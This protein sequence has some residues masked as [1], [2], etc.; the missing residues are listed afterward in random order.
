L[1]NPTI[2]ELAKL[3]GVS[4]ATVSRCVNSPEKVGKKTLARVR[5]IIEETNFSPNALAQN[6]RRGKTN[7]IL[8]IIHDVGNPLFSAILEGV[9][10]ALAG[11]YS[12][13]L[14]EAGPHGPTGETVLG[15]LVARQVEGVILLCAPLPFSRKIVEMSRAR[16]L[17]IVIGL[18]PLSDD[19]SGLPNVHIDNFRAAHEATSYLISLGHK[20]IVFVSGP[21][22]SLVTRDREAGFLSAMRDGG[23]EVDKA[24]V[25]YSDLSVN[26]GLNAANEI[27]AGLFT[28]S[29]LPTAIFCAN[30]DMALG[31]LSSAAR[32]HIPVPGQLSLMGF[33]DTCYAA[34]STPALSTVSQPARDIGIRAAE[35]LLQAIEMQGDH[36][37]ANEI[38]P[39][40][41]VVRQSTRA[42]P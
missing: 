19:L 35:R 8:V 7:I 29:A 22:N 12:I 27:F 3:A 10:L 40:R 15:M 30:D 20:N 32:H 41:L 33:D 17:P 14:T 6:F 1:A 36:G 4:I 37:P 2:T 26:G 16:R 23:L 18:E 9:R 24:S 5:K 39:H 21:K 34:V 25:R 11:R 28:G 38:L 42:I 31:V 13:I